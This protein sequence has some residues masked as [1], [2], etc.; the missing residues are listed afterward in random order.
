M[1][2]LHRSSR[3]RCTGPK[4]KF[5]GNCFQPIIRSNYRKHIEFC[6]D[7]KPLEN[8]RPQC[9]TTLSFNNWQKT[10]WCPFVVYAD[11]EAIDVT[12][13]N[14][15][16][17]TRMTSHTTEI[18]KQY[19]TSF[20]AVLFDQRNSSI[21]KSSFYKEKDCIERLMDTLR[22]W[23]SSTY[24]QTQKHRQLKLSQSEREQLMSAPGI[25]CCI[26]GANVDHGLRVVHPCHLTGFVFGVARS[27]CNLKAR[28][29]NFL[30]VIFI[31]SLY[32]SHHIIKTLLLKEHEKLFAI[33]RTDEVFISFSITV[34]VGSYTTK[35]GKVVKVSHALRFL[36]SFQFMA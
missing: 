4:S 27:E 17:Q 26:C 33:S 6:E 1:H 16:Q 5:C 11:L 23:L 31:T 9:V 19:P 32:D 35:K 29:V 30:P 14:G 25:E 15:S 20:G 18:E 22:I 24:L 8:T 28:S 7:H 2:Q 13:V 10:Q 3:K 36:D 34:P 21:A 12:S